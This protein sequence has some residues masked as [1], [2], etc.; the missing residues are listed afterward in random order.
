MLQHSKESEHL[1][2]V[3]HPPL[4]RHETTSLWSSTS[5]DKNVHALAKIANWIEKY[6]KIR[7]KDGPLRLLRF[8]AIQEILLQYVAWCWLV[9]IPVRVATPKSRQLGS[10]TF[11]EAL[12]YALCELIPGY[13]AAI[14]AHTDDGATELF[15][16]VTVIKNQLKKSAWDTSNL[17]NDQGSYLQWDSD[18]ALWCATIKTGD[19]LGK[20]GTLSAIHFSEVA[21]FSD[22]RADSGKAIDAI[23]NSMA[24]TAR[25]F[26]VYE[27]TAK[28]HDPVFQ[29]LCEAARDRE[30][31]QTI[32]LIFLPWFLD[33]GY[34]LDWLTYRREMVLT[35]KEDPGEKFV[36]TKEEQTLKDRLAKQV[37]QTHEQL[38]RYR[39][40]L[41]NDQLI[42]RRWA[43]ANKCRN[44]P[45]TFKQYYPSFYEECWTASSTS[46]F[47]PE[48]V[49]HFKA[50]AKEPLARGT[51]NHVVGKYSFEPD[52]F[53]AVHL[54]SDPMPN[55]E[56]VIGV[57]VGG[58]TARSDPHEVYVFNKHTREQ[59]AYMSGR[60]EE[61]DF[62]KLVFDLGMYYNRALLVVENN[63][64]PVV[65]KTIF[66]D[67]YPNQYCYFVKER[68]DAREGKVPG[69][70]T[71]KRT[72]PELS[73]VIR[74]LCRDKQVVIYDPGF[75][76][77]MPT[78]VWVPHVTATNP[79]MQGEYKSMG[80]NHDDKIMAA[81][82]ALLQ[83]EPA[84]DEDKI[85][86]QAEGTV[87][88]AWEF[89]LSLSN[90]DKHKSQGAF[91]L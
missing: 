17:V 82:I 35:G 39:V 57:D 65:A 14:V 15:G 13:N 83:C 74:R 4:H 49:E 48:T 11:W 20:G 43:I 8:N 69:W 31:G 10:S 78:F 26:E 21:N 32:Q 33:S 66:N 44:D 12:F 52:P 63:H 40:K 80:A 60:W 3:N 30:S 73:A 2:L 85:V 84:P 29:P 37:V 47:D 23:V 88:K 89:F 16:K 54:W 79:E 87:N 76:Q 27:S 41:T 68:H 6:V 34:T 38:F 18:S 22:K 86:P 50:M 90:K 56:Y 46:A 70:N 64:S 62:A 51:I 77:Q 53:G 42:W 25:M 19:G 1:D 59:A 81:A 55:Q 5:P 58:T 67:N 24:K 7:P 91:L 9:K 61:V 71:N 72:K 45:V 36:A 28:G 75:W